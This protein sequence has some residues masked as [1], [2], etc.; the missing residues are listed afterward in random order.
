MSTAASANWL[1]DEVQLTL[2]ALGFRTRM[3][4][5]THEYNMQITNTSP[6]IVGRFHC[7]FVCAIASSINNAQKSIMMNRVAF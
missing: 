3:K 5:H 2:T 1:N 4:Y 6:N 7:R